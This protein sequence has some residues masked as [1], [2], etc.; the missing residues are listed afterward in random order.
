DLGVT[1]PALLKRFGNRQA[2]L[3]AALRPSLSP[4]WID[5]VDAGPTRGPLASQL[6]DMFA[7]IAAHM[8][9]AVPCVMALRESGLPHEQC[10]PDPAVHERGLLA[11]RQWLDRARRAGLVVAT[12]LDAVAY[13]IVG[14]LQT[15]AF[16]SHLMQRKTTKRE[17]RAYAEQLGR[18]FARGL[19]LP[20][21][22]M[23]VRVPSV[24]KP[25]GSRKRARAPREES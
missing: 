5:K 14:A 2:L 6:A 1:S 17:Q 22:A 16:F 10:F 13:A 11:V 12:E 21:E 20:D 9:E 23:T 18:F 19:A 15:R 25:A 24:A 3:V 4:A 7:H 8:H